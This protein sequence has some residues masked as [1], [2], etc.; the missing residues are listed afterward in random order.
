MARTLA[1]RVFLAGLVVA[2]A[3]QPSS[4]EFINHVGLRVPVT[5]RASAWR[6]TSASSTGFVI[7]GSD[8]GGG[9][10]GVVSVVAIDGIVDGALRR[11]LLGAMGERDGDFEAGPSP[12]AWTAGLLADY[13]KDAAKPG[14]QSLGLRPHVLEALHAADDVIELES[15]LR[16]WLVAANGGDE[17]LV[18]SR[19]PFQAL[20]LGGALGGATVVGNAPVADDGVDY[21]WHVDSDPVDAAPSPWRDAFGAYPNRSRGK[22]RWIT[23]LVYVSREW[24]DEWA[25]PTRFLDPAGPRVLEVRPSPG[26]VVLFDA[27]LSPSVTS[28]A[29]A[30]DLRARFSLA[31][32]LVVHPGGGEMAVLGGAADG[33]GVGFGSF[34]ALCRDDFPT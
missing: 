27:D 13:D 10:E 19:M 2:A 26:R 5:T 25:A 28:P 20:G 22:P 1:L 33:P 16:A 14:V 8:V 17:G 24:R 32:K 6:P 9:D 21:A 23:A 12:D 30:A 29:A 4:L 11:A 31:L 34:R 7:S 3:R 15:R 18:L